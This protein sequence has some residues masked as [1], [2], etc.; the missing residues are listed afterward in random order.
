MA[1]RQAHLAGDKPSSGGDRDVTAARMTVTTL[2]LRPIRL[3]S[4]RV[5]VTLVATAALTGFIA[6]ATAFLGFAVAVAIALLWCV[7]LE[8]H[9][10][11]SEVSPGPDGGAEIFAGGPAQMAS[12]T[13][14]ALPEEQQ[15][16]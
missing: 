4:T 12:D 9:R 10:D 14:S 1:D 13:T 11:P 5:A 7:W 2:A 6:V 15:A 3:R 16:A 8:R